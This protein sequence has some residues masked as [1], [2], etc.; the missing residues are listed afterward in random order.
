M[1]SHL[2]LHSCP[3]CCWPRSPVRR[4]RRSSSRCPLP[5]WWAR[6]QLPT[7]HSPPTPRTAISSCC[8]WPAMWTRT[9]STSRAR[10]TRGAVG[11]HR[12]PS[13]HNPAM[14]SPTPKPLLAARGALAL[15]WTNSMPV[16][17]RRFPAS[18]LRFS[19]SIDGG[20]TWTAA[21]TL[22]MTALARRPA[23]RFTVPRCRAIRRSLWAG[24]TAVKANMRACAVT[25]RFTMTAAPRS[26]RRAPATWARRGSAAT[27]RAGLRH[28]R[29]AGSLS[30]QTRRARCSR[31]GA[32]IS[33]AT[34]AIRSLLG[35]SPR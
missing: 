20:Q 31:R 10:P 2:N 26:I 6:P 14:S 29:A 32:D 33:R 25:V 18:N 12:C 22:T 8:G 13:P 4:E 23:I 19:R 28:A 30:P 15:F 17:G 9:I 34:S 35:S 27:W 16:Q 5:R 1:R 21:I 24:S 3:G 11:R 7:L